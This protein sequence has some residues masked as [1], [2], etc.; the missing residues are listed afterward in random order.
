M[1]TEIERKSVTTGKIKLS[2]KDAI[3][4]F[5][6]AKRA[7]N[8][9]ENTIDN[10]KYTFSD[11]KKFLDEE[12]TIASFDRSIF[13]KYLIHLQSQDRDI[14]QS[15][16]SINYRNLHTLF[17]WLVT[18]EYIESNPL[19]E[20]SKPKTK[21]KYPRILNEEQTK[22]LLKAAKKDIKR[23]AGQRNY[24]MLQM[25]IE[26]GLRLN[27]LIKAVISDLDI[28]E[29]SL[30]VC[31]KGGKERLVSFG[32]QLS[33]VLRKWLNRREELDKIYDENIFISEKGDQLKKRNVQRIITRIQKKAGLEDEKVSAHVLRH[34]SATLV[35]KEG[36]RVYE[37]KQVYGWSKTETAEKYIHLSGRDVK[38]AV[39]KAS[40]IDNL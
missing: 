10:Y 40:P 2:L 3:K 26:T 34:T 15:T 6:Y 37:L 28:P 29:H 22:T 35:A 17:E 11:F 7:E 39:R 36:M 27:E 18:E 21:D 30:K 33:K 5:L 38:K 13:R 32:S 16:V 31:G 9:S 25:F 1:K 8:V 14:S 23:L 20:I 19:A 4:E 24:T 12:R